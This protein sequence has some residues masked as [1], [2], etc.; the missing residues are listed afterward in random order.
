M[1]VTVSDTRTKMILDLSVVS[2]SYEINPSAT[3]ESIFTC[4]QKINV[5]QN[6]QLKDVIK[7]DILTLTNQ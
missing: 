5:F 2:Y 4:A 1:A 3:L 6:H 7:R